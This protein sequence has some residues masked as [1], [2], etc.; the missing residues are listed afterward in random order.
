MI[1][2]Y[3]IVCSIRELYGFLLSVDFV[4]GWLW[5]DLQEFTTDGDGGF[6]YDM[7]CVD[8]KTIIVTRR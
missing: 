2:F 1:D 3:I 8:A 5:E 6:G 4:V 7:L